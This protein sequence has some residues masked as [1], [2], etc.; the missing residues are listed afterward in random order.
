MNRNLR[1]AFV[2]NRRPY[3]DM[4]PG[5]W[6]TFLQYHTELP[7]YYAKHAK[8]DVTFVTSTRYDYEC[9][10]ASGGTL[11]C[12]SEEQYLD[13][14]QTGMNY[15]VI[16]HWRKWF[17]ELYCENSRNVI[18]AQDQSYSEDWKRVVIEAHEAGQ[19]DGII[20][21]PTWHMEHVREQLPLSIKLYT[22]MT[23]G[24]DT[25]IYKS[26]VTKNPYQLLWAS[27]PG[28]GLEKLISP[29]LQLW[30]QDRR[31]N[32]VVTYPDYV[33]S[34]VIAR[35]ASFL[36]HPAV[37]H[38]PSVRNGP[39]LWNLFNES[40][41]LPYSSTFP[42]PYSRV[43]RQMMASEGVVLYPPDMGTPSHL[44]ATGLTGIVSMPSAWPEQI[45]KM[46]ETGLW[47]TIGRNARAFAVSENWAVQAQ[48]FYSFFS[49][50][51]TK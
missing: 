25:D 13:D 6:A 38:R 22:N 47:Q 30:A 42:E 27:D 35:Y 5:Y 2:G 51:L 49:K 18:L 4:P 10:F 1:V 32:L 19:L 16:V 33:K 40:V 15:D 26:A 34:D 41:F 23:C 48:R 12:I 21:F 45:T 7:W 44:I 37:S 50:D 11:T 31:F 8:I 17:P 24:V 43:C 20:V 39:A 28:R 29:F 46:I 14:P 9:E 36:R 3:T